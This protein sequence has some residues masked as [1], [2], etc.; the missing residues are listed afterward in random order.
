MDTCVDSQLKLFPETFIRPFKLMQALRADKLCGHALRVKATG[1]LN[2]DNRNNN[3]NTYALC[4][5]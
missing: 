4:E 1:V 2:N 3:A 5:E